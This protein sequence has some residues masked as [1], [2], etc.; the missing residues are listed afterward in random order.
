MGWG[1]GGDELIGGLEGSGGMGCFE[2]RERRG[3][4]V[5]CRTKTF[6]VPETTKR[7]KTGSE[8]QNCQLGDIWA[9]ILN[10]YGEKR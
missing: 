8:G 9:S 4:S 5:F 2:G 7:L 10:F 1:Y 3:R 6:F